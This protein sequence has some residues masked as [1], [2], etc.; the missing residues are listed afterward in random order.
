GRADEVTKVRGMFVHPRQ[1]DAVAGRA[2]GVSRYQ[3]VVTRQEHQ[4]VLTFQVALAPGADAAAVAAALPGAIL[5]VL[6]RRGEVRVVPAGSIPAGS[7]KI[8]DQRK[9]D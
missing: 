7:R 1:V 8:E 5:D 6:K 9:W 4:D 3:A 2:A